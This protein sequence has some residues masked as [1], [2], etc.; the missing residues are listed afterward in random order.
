M[1]GL[2]IIAPLQSTHD[3]QG[4][5]KE[6]CAGKPAMNS[7]YGFSIDLLWELKRLFNSPDLQ[8]PEPSK[9]KTILATSQDFMRIYWDLSCEKFPSINYFYYHYYWET[10]FRQRVFN[11]RK[12]RH[13]KNNLWQKK[14][15]CIKCWPP[16]KIWHKIVSIL[17]LSGDH[18]YNKIFL[19]S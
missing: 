8:C 4:W 3:I 14:F 11:F 10:M 19:H 5:W 17:I 6:Q 13:K 9:N 12:A 7:N 15:F 16:P 2:S 18:Y 1:W